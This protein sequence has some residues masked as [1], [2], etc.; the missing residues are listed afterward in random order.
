MGERVEWPAT[1]PMGLS[2]G[3]HG[4]AAALTALHPAWWPAAVGAIAGNHALLAAAGMWPRSQIFG[5]TLYR[6]PDAGSCVALTFDDGPHPDVTPRV[7]DLLAGSGAK[8]SF[9]CI[10]AYARKHPVL[11]RQ[12]SAAGHSIENHTLTHPNNFSCLLTP[13]LRREV[14]EAQAI[15]ADIIGR[16]PCWFRSPMGFRSPLLD[17]VLR[18]IGLSAAAW[19]RRGYDT[20]CRD[21][22]IVLRRLLRGVRAGDVLMLHDC[23]SACMRDGTP[24]VLGVLPRLL[25]SLAQQGLSVV[26]LPAATRASAPVAESRTSAGYAS[27]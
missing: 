25:T 18:S 14:G 16:A 17:P 13:Q 12:L 2:A 11:L 24:V 15:L 10:G 1:L 27:M 26:A 6:L 21:P 20:R 22:G 19:T 9:F 5:K 23:H 3:L 4:A 7:V 8:A